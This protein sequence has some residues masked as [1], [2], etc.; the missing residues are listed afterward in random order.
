MVKGVRL[1]AHVDV[2]EEWVSRSCLSGSLFESRDAAAD[3]DYRDAMPQSCIIGT[4]QLFAIPRGSFAA[5][6]SG[7]MIRPANPS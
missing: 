3:N 2:V 7:I 4:Q 5:S 6:E 1:G